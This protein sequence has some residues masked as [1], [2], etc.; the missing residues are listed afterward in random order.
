MAFHVPFQ[1]FNFCPL[2]F[3]AAWQFEQYNRIVQRISNNQKIW[4]LD[5]TML[6]QI[7]WFNQ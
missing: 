6:Q 1:H 7:C 5:L 3:M 2:A 4:E